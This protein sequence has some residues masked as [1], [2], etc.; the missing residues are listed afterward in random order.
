VKSST[1]FERGS[2]DRAWAHV[3]LEVTEAFA[4]KPA[5]EVRRRPQELGAL[6]V[7]D[8]GG[9]R[10][11]VH[12]SAAESLPGNKGTPRLLTREQKEGSMNGSPITVGFFR[13][14]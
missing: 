11:R 2:I 9:G 13:P 8:V 7:L 3:V 4:V 14:M 12:H 1:I 6:V 5:L 10:F